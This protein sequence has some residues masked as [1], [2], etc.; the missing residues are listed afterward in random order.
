MNPR[1]VQ[2]V[3]VEK[4][5]IEVNGVKYP[6]KVSIETKA[7]Y[8]P[9]FIS[10]N[11]FKEKHV[12]IKEKSILFQIDDEIV[13]DD[14]DNYMIDENYILKTIVEKVKNKRLN[15]TLIK[16]LTRS[17]KNLQDSKRIMIRGQEGLA[18]DYTL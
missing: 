17:E 3:S 18:I 16:L 4:G 11:D 13:L 10:L 5:E 6:A 12:D 1:Y 2:D 15:F 7:D 8:R 14:Y 9:N